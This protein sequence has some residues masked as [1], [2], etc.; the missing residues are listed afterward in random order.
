M[1]FAD[2]GLRSFEAPASLRVLGQG[3]FYDCVFLR[4]V[5][6]NEGLEELGPGDDYRGVF[7]STSVEEVTLP[8]TLR[9]IGHAVFRE[10]PGLERVVLQEGLQAIGR[11]CFDAGVLERIT[12]PASLR[13]IEGGARALCRC[14][15]KVYVREGCVVRPRW[16][17][18]NVVLLP[19]Q[20]TRVGGVRLG[21]L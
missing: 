20:K 1:A 8:S 10:C 18:P 7:R 11:T 13:T 6:L 9:R 19:P 5:V 15:R 12:L 17:A 3:A 16:T 21:Q 4:R 14:F 2:S